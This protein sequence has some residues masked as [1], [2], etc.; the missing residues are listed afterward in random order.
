M[1]IYAKWLEGMISSRAALISVFVFMLSSWG[2]GE[3]LLAHILKLSWRDRVFGPLVSTVAGMNILGLA[4]FILGGFGVLTPG[5][6]VSLLTVSGIFSF[7]LLLFHLR[8]NIHPLLSAVRRKENMF[9]LIVMSVFFVFF[10]GNYLCPPAGVG[11]DEQTYHLPIPMRWLRDGFF[12]VYADIPYSGYPSL[13][14]FLM[15]IVMGAGKSSAPRVLVLCVH[16]LNLSLFYFLLRRYGGAA[17]SAILVAAL[18]LAGSHMN[19]MY[20]V[21]VEC[22]IVAGLL[23]GLAVLFHADRERLPCLVTAF[24]CGLFGASAAAVKLTAFPVSAVLFFAV[25]ATGG[26]R[27]IWRVIGGTSIAYMIFALPFYLRTWALTGNPLWPYY[28]WIFSRNESV[29]ETSRLFH[30]MGD[31][32][33]FG[34]GGLPEALMSP[35]LLCWND[36]AFD[37][38]WGLQFGLL[39]VLGAVCAYYLIAAKESSPLKYIGIGGFVFSYIFWMFTSRQARFLEPAIIL[40]IL[41]AA[42]ALQRMR[43]DIRLLLLVLIA[44]LS[45]MSSPWNW[46]R[47]YITSWR[48][49]LNEIPSYNFLAVR[50]GGARCEAYS[51][52]ASVAAPSDKVMILYDRKILHCPVNCFIATPFYQASFFTPPPEKGTDRAIQDEILSTMQSS[53]AKYVMVGSWLG[54][55]DKNPAVFE[56][57]EKFRNALSVL[58]T[59]GKLKV[60][61]NSP[62]FMLAEIPRR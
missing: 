41:S 17:M 20:E 16:M 38:D 21:Y 6:S 35:F 29:I 28:G 5:G 51:K 50:L 30:M 12:H 45:L 2:L 23:A 15:A 48:I 24:I 56:R 3:L 55:I 27:N 8:Q 46:V 61:W 43:N 33:S 25:A 57:T 14:E 26:R 10:L 36:V 37:G 22:F 39:L 47:H 4:G 13:P 58:L 34:Q 1:D 42:Y 44:A 31:A 54:G 18:F 49:V 40:L 9:F 52:L 62:D 59:N 11:L 7:G 19:F 60:I 32:N 53:G